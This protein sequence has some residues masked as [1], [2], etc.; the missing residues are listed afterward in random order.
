MADIEATGMAKRNIHNECYYCAHNRPVP[1]NCHIECVKPD[2][3]MTG[4]K[5]GIRKGWFMYP[6]LF[7]PVWKTRM[8]GNF[9]FHKS[10]NHAISN[11]VS[12]ETNG[13][14]VQG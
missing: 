14:D 8:C 4:D 5:H 1:G 2:A 11:A 6:L 10:V 13:P 7:D 3:K 12:Q 9:K